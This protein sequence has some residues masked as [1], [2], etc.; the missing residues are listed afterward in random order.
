MG[1]I[2]F[3]KSPLLISDGNFKG[4]HSKVSVLSPCYL[5]NSIGHANSFNYSEA[6]WPNLVSKL[7]KSFDDLGQNAIIAF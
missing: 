4:N 2:G 3:I 6:T 1:K 5:K 7:P